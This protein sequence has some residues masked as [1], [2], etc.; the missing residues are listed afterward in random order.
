MLPSIVRS[1]TTIIDGRRRALA[2]G[3]VTATA[4]FL[5]SDATAQQDA[6]RAIT[7]DAALEAMPDPQG[8]ALMVVNDGLQPDAVQAIA[9]MLQDAMGE[10]HFFGAVYAYLP[11]GST[12][13]AIR[14]RNGLHSPEAADRMALQDCEAERGDKDSPCRLLA[15]V[16]PEDWD[17]ATGL[18]LSSDAAHAVTQAAD[19]MVRPL[20]LARSRDTTRFSVWSGE[21]ARQ[22]A[23]DECDAAVEADGAM[24]DCDLVIDDLAAR[25]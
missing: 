12:Q 5:A 25:D 14:V 23:L 7:S 20:F 18:P 8:Y 4:S 16:M 6:S 24:P 3:L 13:L 15:T 10:R 21:T 22:T 2:L 17:A 19:Q 9:R 11:E 1:V